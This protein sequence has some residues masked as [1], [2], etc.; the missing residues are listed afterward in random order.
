VPEPSL[1]LSMVAALATLGVVYRRR[2]K[3]SE[4]TP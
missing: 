4:G 1:S 3:G 2:R